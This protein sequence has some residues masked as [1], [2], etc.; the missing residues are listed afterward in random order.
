[1]DGT[2]VDYMISTGRVWIGVDRYEHELVRIAHRYIA[3]DPTTKDWGKHAR[4][5]F[6]TSG[7]YYKGLRHLL[8]NYPKMPRITKIIRFNC[9]SVS[10]RMRGLP[11]SSTYSRYHHAFLIAPKEYL[12]AR[13]FEIT[14]Q[15][16]RVRFGVQNLQSPERYLV[17]DE[18]TVV[19]S[20]HPDSPVRQ[21]VVDLAMPAMKLWE[22]EKD[23]TKV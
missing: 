12:D 19:F 11:Y 17:V 8:D 4:L 10:P 14:G 23:E 7:A 22:N 1:M 16:V 5:P 15:Q 21:I 20:S 13:N 9:G 2:K 18:E 3:R 6:I